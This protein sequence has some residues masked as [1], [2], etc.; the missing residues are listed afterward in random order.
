MTPPLYILVPVHNRREITR[1]F[2]RCLLNQTFQNWHLVL[3]D[4]GSDDGTSEMAAE[5]VRSLT[6]FR[7]D[8]NW[9]WARSLQ[10]GIDWLQSA[11]RHDDSI[12]LIINDDTEFD[13]DF[14]ESGVSKIA[15]G[16][17]LIVKPFGYDCEKGHLVDA[18]I[19]FDWVSLTGSIIQGREEADCFS[20]RG[21]FLTMSALLKI[22]PF[23]PG[24]LPHYLSDYEF[25]MRAKRK[26]VRLL[27]DPSFSLKTP[28]PAGNIKTMPT[29][30]ID[31]IEFITSNLC[32]RNPIH[33]LFFVLMAAPWRWKLWGSLL[34]CYRGLCD[35]TGLSLP[36]QLGKKTSTAD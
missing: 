21:I 7:G 30:F 12:V 28:D 32:H 25:T 14:L 18:G 23:H 34:V 2:I 3:I 31:R 35:L 5:L 20:T 15:S 36:F 24:L 33:W 4:D 29:K 27:A 10:K 17:D 6:L 16:T 8:G 19:A 26:G 1:S 9:W 22:G 11:D 13:A